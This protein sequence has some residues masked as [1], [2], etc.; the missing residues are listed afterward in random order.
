[1]SGSLVINVMALVLMLVLLAAAEQALK[2]LTG[3]RL[4][5][6]RRVLRAIVY[7]AGVCAWALVSY[8]GIFRGAGEWWFVSFLAVAGL[9]KLIVDLFIFGAPQRSS[10][11]RADR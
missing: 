10:S 7:L 8:L 6:S 9:W 3:R 5:R 2:R 4:D 1:M 11:P